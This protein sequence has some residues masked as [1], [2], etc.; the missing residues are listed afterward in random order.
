VDVVRCGIKDADLCVGKH[1]QRIKCG[2]A[3]NK[4]AKQCP[5]E[6][7]FQ[8]LNYI[9]TMI[10]VVNNFLHNIFKEK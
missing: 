9:Q 6:K 7:Y 8:F 5:D 3:F 10:N 4:N 2:I 1:E